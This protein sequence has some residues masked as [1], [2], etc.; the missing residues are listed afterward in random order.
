MSIDI[1]INIKK[2]FSIFV[3]CIFL[4]IFEL[5]FQIQKFNHSDDDDEDEEYD[6]FA[7]EN[8]Y[9][10]WDEFDDDDLE[11]VDTYNPEAEAARAFAEDTMGTRE[12]LLN[13]DCFCFLTYSMMFLGK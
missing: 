3:I 4:N 5:T 7:D 13:F 12:I 10:S 9:E 6:P 1:D 8:E 11:E 2:C